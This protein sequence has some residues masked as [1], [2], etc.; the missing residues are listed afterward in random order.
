MAK[1]TLDNE[2][3][4]KIDAFLEEISS[5]V[6]QTTLESVRSALGE[7]QGYAPRGRGLPRSVVSTAPRAARGGA[8]GKRSTEEVEQMA[9]RIAGYVRSNPGV[10]LDAI[11]SGLGTST[12]ELKLPVIKLLDS[13]GLKKTGQKRGTKYFPGAKVIF[14]RGGGG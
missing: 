9:Q 8:G 7:G 1:T 5:L 10:R 2:L 14:T 6:K 13:K 3:R 4:S 12:K 11:A